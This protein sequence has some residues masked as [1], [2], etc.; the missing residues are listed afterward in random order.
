VNTSISL[1]ICGRLYAPLVNNNGSVMS[2]EVETSSDV[3]KG[4]ATGLKAWPRGLRL[5]RCS[6]DSA[7]NDD[8]LDALIRRSPLHPASCILQQ[9]LCE[10][11]RM[12]R[13]QFPCGFDSSGSNKNANCAA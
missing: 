11:D 7:R 1:P 9:M 10:T 6:L 3:T 5:L 12:S 4:S 8:L 13:F 2:S